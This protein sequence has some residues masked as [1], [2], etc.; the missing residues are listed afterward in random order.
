MR[1]IEIETCRAIRDA[2]VAA[3]RDTP[4]D[5]KRANMRVYWIE[6]VPDIGRY[7]VMVELHGNRICRI[8]KTAGQNGYTLEFNNAGW[9]TATTKSRI[10]AIASEFSANG[11][12]EQ[13]D[14]SWFWRQTVSRN[15]IEFPHGQW[16]RAY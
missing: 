3:E 11:R 8:T 16:F 10:N 7:A 14:Y 13:K 15:L 1:I 2:M 4:F 9:P 6:L 12:V 5:W